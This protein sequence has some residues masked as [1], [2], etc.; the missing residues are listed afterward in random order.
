MTVGILTVTLLIPESFSLK[1]KR[2]VLQGLK[3]RLRQDLNVS[4]AE[5]D[6]QE[7]WNRAT[8]GIAA[9]GTDGTFVRK[10]CDE[11][12]ARIRREPRVGISGR[13]LELI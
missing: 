9:V 11:A 13:E 8:L 6:H 5:V 3:A 12:V 10:V 7:E 2:S 4:V 1:D